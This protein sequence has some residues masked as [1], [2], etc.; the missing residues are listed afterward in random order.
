MITTTRYII[1]DVSIHR[2]NWVCPITI[3]PVYLLF[4]KNI[5][6]TVKKSIVKNGKNDRS[7]ASLQVNFPG[8]VRE[9]GLEPALLS[10]RLSY[11]VLSVVW[12]GERKGGVSASNGNIEAFW[13]SVHAFSSKRTYHPG[14]GSGSL[15]EHKNHSPLCSPLCII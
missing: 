15:V 2:K 1:L 10:G 8:D 11:L 4:L 14:D 3:H 9:S 7:A 5:Q 12:N 6:C 13:S